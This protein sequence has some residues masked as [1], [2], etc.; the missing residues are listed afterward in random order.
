MQLRRFAAVILAVAVI[1]M[2]AVP[3]YAYNDPTVGTYNYNQ[4]GYY[5][6]GYYP[7]DYN[8]YG[9]NQTQYYNQYGYNQNYYGSYGYNQNGFINGVN[10]TGNRVSYG[11]I[12]YQYS[13]WFVPYAQQYGISMHVDPHSKIVRS[14]VFSSG[15]KAINRAYERAGRRFSTSF[16]VPFVDFTWDI[17]LYQ[18][19]GGLYQT[20]IMS[21]YREDNTV[22]FA[23][24]IKREEL[25]KVLVEEANVDGIYN[26]YTSI[27][28]QFSDIDGRWSKQYIE[29][30]NALGLM[31]GRDAYHFC[32]SDFVTYEEYVAIMLRMAERA[33][34]AN[35]H[36]YNN[37]SFNVEDIEYAI[38][39]SM[40]IDFNGTS[41]LN[42]GYT[43]GYTTYVS[44]ITLNPTDLQLQIGGNRYITATVMPSNA[45][46]KGLT[47]M[48]YNTNVATVD[49]NG[50]ITAVGVGSTT[51][52]ATANDGSGI[53]ASVNVTVT[54]GQ[55]PVS[56]TVTDTSAPKVQIT[57]ADN[58]SVGQF[59]TLK[60]KVTD[61][62]LSSFNIVE[63]DLLGLTGGASINSI[64]KVSNDTYEI[65]LMGVEVSSLALC[66][67]AG[68]AQDTAGNLSPESNEVVIFVN[69]G[70]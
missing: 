31:V 50:Q 19:A 21:G 43:Y 68:V 22:R 60:V 63:G 6:T 4:Y 67:R 10:C 51:V 3:T 13:S 70:E 26:G 30:C 20:G 7:Y 5:Q 45:T 62:N 44:S 1:L 39:D 18:I 23:N 36:Y 42:N 32:P 65:R 33:N 25:A 17:N 58:V 34:T 38:S 46:N 69:S 56:V 14:D 52:T 53:V 61:D 29:I 12:T 8:Q 59:V 66:I 40:D 57:G 54:S 16:G 11:Q 49:Q 37:Y 28:S 41:S 2:M 24:F 9:Y 64:T 47:W 15:G 48:S 27:N 35:G 55:T